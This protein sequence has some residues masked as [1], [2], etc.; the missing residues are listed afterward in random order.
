VPAR[1]CSQRFGKGVRLLG[2]IEAS[3]LIDELLETC[4][5]LN[6][7]NGRGAPRRNA[8]AANRKGGVR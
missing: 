6:R 7:G 8:Y 5:A 3:G 2:K 4:N 1:I